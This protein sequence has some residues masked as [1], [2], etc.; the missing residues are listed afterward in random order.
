MFDSAQVSQLGNFWRDMRENVREAQE[1]MPVFAAAPLIVREGLLFPYL[2]GAEFMRWFESAYPDTQPY[3]R[4]MP[5]ST[6]Q[7]LH[8]DRYR[9]GDEPTSLRFAPTSAA[10]GELV[11]E[12]DWGELET[13]IVLQEL[14][15]SESLA[16][17]GALGWDGDRFAVFRA[18]G[19]HAL[20]WWS[21]WDTPV[22]AEKF[23]A[24]L[25]RSWGKRSGAGRR[26][27]VER[28][29]LEGRPAVR[30]LDGPDGWAGWGEPPAVEI[31]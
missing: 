2:A 23:A 10:L 20:A 1:R 14:T 21:V 12:D 3:G 29:A 16:T 27:S 6:E 28:Q 4:R 30:L 7:I 26:W 13:R 11:Y 17:A 9:G 5:R 24:M 8:P 22:A 15:G 25:E 31:R 19:T 18:T